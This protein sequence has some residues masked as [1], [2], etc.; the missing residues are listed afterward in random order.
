MVDNT[1]VVDSCCEAF[2]SIQ[3]TLY[4][5]GTMPALRIGDFQANVIELYET[6]S[7]KK[8]GIAPTDIFNCLVD[9]CPFTPL[10][11]V[12]A[13]SLKLLILIYNALLLR[14]FNDCLDG[15]PITAIRTLILYKVFGCKFPIT[16]KQ[17]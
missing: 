9:T 1:P 7:A 12:D 2:P 14:T 6:L 5:S 8:D 13:I 16:N 3:V 17:Y 11:T 4:L 10:S 15:D